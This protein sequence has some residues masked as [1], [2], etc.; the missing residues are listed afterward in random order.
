[1]HTTQNAPASGADPDRRGRR[2]RDG[3]LTEA[4]LPGARERILAAAQRL[5]SAHGY[6]ATSV[7]SI[8][9][10]AQMTTPNLYWHF[11]SKQ[12]LLAEVLEL[13]FRQ[14]QED[15]RAV[16]PAT[17]PADERLAAFVRQYVRLQMHSADGVVYNYSVLAADLS[18]DDAVALL[19]SR[20]ETHR[21]LRGIVQEGIDERIFTIEDP[22]LALMAIETSCEYVFTWYRPDRRFTEEQVLEGYVDIALRIVGF[23]PSG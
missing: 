2:S 21:L 3:A 12:A 8:A 20:R 7:A 11:P 23:Q 22:T 10:A 9:K 4:E 13:E 5:F 19:D 6:S 17:G 16:L 15:L 18:P 14:F 1:V